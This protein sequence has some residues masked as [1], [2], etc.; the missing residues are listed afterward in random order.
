MNAGSIYSDGA[1]FDGDE[2]NADWIGK[3]TGAA[4]SVADL[5]RIFDDVGH[6]GNSVSMIG[7][8]GMAEAPGDLREESSEGDNGTASEDASMQE[9]R[10]RGSDSSDDLP[11][12]HDSEDSHAAGAIVDSYDM[13][14]E[15]A[16]AQWSAQIRQAL[17]AMIERAFD[18][19]RLRS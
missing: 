15:T 12:G 2:G 19:T 7:E 11:P 1:S 8:G 16:C 5:R 6:F 10:E 18:S 13:A 17:P 14:I 3:S 9:Q 4:Q